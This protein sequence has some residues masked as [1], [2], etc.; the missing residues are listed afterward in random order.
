MN[1]LA[2]SWAR[3][4]EVLRI[5]RRLQLK[6]N[7]DPERTARRFAQYPGDFERIVASIKQSNAE[8]TAFARSMQ[9][10]TPDAIAARVKEL[11]AEE[12]QLWAI[13]R[14]DLYPIP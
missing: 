1:P 5:R 6:G 13:V 7:P 12:V 2:Q 4:S 14:P 9:L 3:L 11:Q 10:H 8:N